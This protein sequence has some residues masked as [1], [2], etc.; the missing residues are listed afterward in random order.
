MKEKVIF[1][2]YECLYF[3]YLEVGQ[4]QSKQHLFQVAHK[5]DHV[6]FVGKLKQKIIPIRVT[7]VHIMDD[8]LHLQP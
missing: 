8:G 4:Q 6:R 1:F 7:N 3:I 5:V 2:F